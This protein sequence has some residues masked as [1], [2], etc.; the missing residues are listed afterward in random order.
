[1][2]IILNWSDDTFIGVVSADD[3]TPLIFRDSR[4]GGRI[5]RVPVAVQLENRQPGG[6]NSLLSYQP[7]VLDI[8]TSCLNYCLGPRLDTLDRFF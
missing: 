1:M 4:R 2:Y 7:I 5:R 3:G 8:P 6:I